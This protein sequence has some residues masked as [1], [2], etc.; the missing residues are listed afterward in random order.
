MIKADLEGSSVCVEHGASE[1]SSEKKVRGQTVD[2]VMGEPPVL[3][4]VVWSLC[5]KVA[6][7][8]V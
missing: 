5:F 4:S 6:F 1:G 8:K 7:L 2:R 3:G